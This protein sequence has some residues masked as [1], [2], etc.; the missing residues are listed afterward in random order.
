L[1]KTLRE[2]IRLEHS[3]GLVWDFVQSTSTDVY[4]KNG[5]ECQLMTWD[6][7]LKSPDNKMMGSKE[8]VREAFLLACERIIGGDVPRRG[9]T[10]VNIDPSFQYE[11]YFIGHKRA[12]ESLTLGIQISVGDP[13]HDRQHPVWSFLKRLRDHTGWELIDTFTGTTVDPGE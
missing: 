7:V 2:Q 9:P 13:H 12:I 6:V 1:G 3:L 8:Q 11:V 4:L 5:E 10:E